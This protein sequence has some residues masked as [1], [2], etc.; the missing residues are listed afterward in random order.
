MYQEKNRYEMCMP[1]WIRAGYDC[2]N[3]LWLNRTD[4]TLAGGSECAGLY[5]GTLILTIENAR[6]NKNTRFWDPP[7][8]F[9]ELATAT[10]P[11]CRAKLVWSQIRFVA[12]LDEKK[13][14]PTSFWTRMADMFNA[15]TVG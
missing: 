6:K 2:L 7:R 1:F 15:A 3:G 8:D 4:V 12:T 14:L 13:A 5:S 11:A 9:N 10:P